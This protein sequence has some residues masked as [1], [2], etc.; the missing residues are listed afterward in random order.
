MNPSIHKKLFLS[1]FIYCAAC[2]LSPAEIYQWTDKNGN[3]VFG[4][5]PPKNK[6]A[7]PVDIQNTET[8]GTRFATPT[9]VES[10]ER[11]ASRPSTQPRQPQQRIDGQCRRYISELNKVEIY[12][13]H[14]N[15]PRDQHKANDLRKLLKKECSP[16]QLAKKFDD[17]R[18]K[19][20]REDLSK[21]ELFLEHSNNPRDER[22][23]EGL[24]K[25]I[26]RECR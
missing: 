6:A 19:R 24:R 7:T 18:C 21:T 10:L 26:A 22:K 25:Q 11:E 13:E 8:S 20:Y 4:D 12:L 17:W 1:I 16:E 2:G 15:S 9:Q 5:S 23:A 3:T 14:S